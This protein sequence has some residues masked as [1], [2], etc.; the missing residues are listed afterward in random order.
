[1][2]DLDTARNSW[3]ALK[4]YLTL[5]ELREA[6]RLDGQFSIATDGCRSA[7]WKTFL[8]FETLDTSTWTRTLSSTRSAYNSLR[9]HFL[10]HI[11]NL[12]EIDREEDP[13]SESNEVSELN[14]LCRSTTSKSN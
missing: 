11:E 14:P 8:L 5:P 6:V 4:H 13:L 2:R 12:D 7:C 1:M 10:R 9:S 3:Q